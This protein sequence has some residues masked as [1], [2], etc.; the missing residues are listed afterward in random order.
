[1]ESY[2]LMYRYQTPYVFKQLAFDYMV[3]GQCHCVVIDTPDEFSIRRVRNIEH[4]YYDM[5]GN[6]YG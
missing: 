2:A 5:N 3:Y 4:S 1:M 6:Y